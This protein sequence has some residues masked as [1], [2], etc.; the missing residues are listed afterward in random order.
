[1]SRSARLTLLLAL[2]IPS[3]GTLMAADTRQAQHPNGLAETCKV[4]PTLP[5]ERNAAA[6][7]HAR[8]LGRLQALKGPEFDKAYAEHEVAFH[9]AAIEAVKTALLPA[10]QCAAL[11]AHFTEVLPAFAHHLQQTE[12]VAAK[13]AS[14]PK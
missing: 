13:V 5:T 12:A 7:D 11:K 10:A 14:V 8:T 9:R 6:S 1:M 3:G 4:V 2:V